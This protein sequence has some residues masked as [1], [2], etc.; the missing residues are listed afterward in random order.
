MKG[1]RIT[2]AVQPPHS[3]E[4]ECSTEVEYE[5]RKNNRS[6]PTSTFD[7][8]QTTQP[9]LGKIIVDFISYKP[10][11][12]QRSNYKTYINK[13]INFFNSCYFLFCLR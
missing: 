2:E 7:R 12:L 1:G 3:T 13:F 5:R 10:F 4:V 9:K 8:S 11:G 6:Y